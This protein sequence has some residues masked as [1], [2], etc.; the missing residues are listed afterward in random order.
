MSVMAT[1]N[2]VFT[3]GADWTEKEELLDVIYWARQIIGLVLGAIWGLAPLHGF[4]EE[5]KGGEEGRVQDRGHGAG[6]LH[7][8]CQC[9]RPGQ[10]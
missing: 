1:I 3:G 2:K 7:T 9:T 4:L 6:G 8:Q 5:K 10:A